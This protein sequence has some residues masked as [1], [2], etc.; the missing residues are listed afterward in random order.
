MV[1]QTV[2]RSLIRQL[3]GPHIRLFVEHLSMR[4]N[5][6][7]HMLLLF[8]LTTIS[9]VSKRKVTLSEDQ[10]EPI[11]LWLN[12]CHVGSTRTSSLIN[13]LEHSLVSSFKQIS[14]IEKEKGQVELSKK[15]LKPNT[16]GCAG[17]T[18]GLLKL[19]TENTERAWMYSEE[20]LRSVSMLAN[21]RG[22]GV[23]SHILQVNYC[24]SKKISF[25][26][27]TAA[28]MFIGRLSW[29]KIPSS[30]WTRRLV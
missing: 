5:T 22:N 11:S 17:S 13:R 9:V 6:P 21:D 20:G 29:R 18:A 2:D 3:L 1:N 8:L 25:S 7:F 26:G 10:V 28:G 27:C 15:L 14:E 24:L 30:L 12:W 4:T 23:D 19:L 16:T